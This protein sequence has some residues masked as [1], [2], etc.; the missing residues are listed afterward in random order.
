[1]PKLREEISDKFESVV[2][3]KAKVYATSGTPGKTL[4]KN[5]GPM[6]ELVDAYRSMVGKIKYYAT[7]IAPMI[8]KAVAVHLS[9]V[10]TEHWKALE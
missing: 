9:N 8:C 4:V 2:G 7:K 5:I 10:G 6:V 3:K 1:M